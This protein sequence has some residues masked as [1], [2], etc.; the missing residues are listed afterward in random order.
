MRS[1]NR[2]NSS[3]SISH[4]F[5]F[6]LRVDFAAELLVVDVRVLEVERDDEADGR[7]EELLRV[8]LLGTARIDGDDSCLG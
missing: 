7:A 3:A 8:E 6:L 5:F 2:K 1:S 4:H